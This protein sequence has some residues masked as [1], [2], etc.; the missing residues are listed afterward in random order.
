MIRVSESR[1]R[2]PQIQFNEVFLLFPPVK[3]QR[4][5]LIK[6]LFKFMGRNIR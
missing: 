2:L 6:A 1:F 5:S 3:E 4:K